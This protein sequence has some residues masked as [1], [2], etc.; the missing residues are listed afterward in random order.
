MI[1]QTISHY[2]I[3]QKL[4]EGGMG[5]V[6][7]AEDTKLNRLVALKFLHQEFTRDAEAKERFIREARAA[8]PLDHPNIRT[9]YKLNETET[10][11]TTIT[12][13]IIP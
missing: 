1:G 8:S 2:K 3:L 4:G 12:G 6:S 7:K 9:I 11:R 5:V 13:N 10:G